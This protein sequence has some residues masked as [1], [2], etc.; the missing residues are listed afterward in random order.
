MKA[1]F[2]TPLVSFELEAG[3]PAELFKLLADTQEVFGERECGACKKTNLRFAVRTVNGDDYYEY[4]CLDCSARLSLG[5]SK[6]KKGHLF[7]IRKLTA[8]GKPSR[9][10][11]TYDSK[12]KGWTKYRGEPE[13]TE[14]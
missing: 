5:Q 7:P 4:Q 6:A 9:K 12:G 1:T 11:G 3:T 14:K 10:E 13:P 8:Q 2:A